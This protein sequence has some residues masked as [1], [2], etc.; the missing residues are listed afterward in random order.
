[1]RPIATKPASAAARP[2]RAGAGTGIWTS[3]AGSVAAAPTAST[4][5]HLQIDA[6]APT[7]RIALRSGEP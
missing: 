1:V 2:V 6:G 4:R 7:L 5:S 3:G